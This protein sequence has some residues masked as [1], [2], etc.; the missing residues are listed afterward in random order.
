MNNHL[1]A[2]ILGKYSDALEASLQ[3]ATTGAEIVSAMTAYDDT[4]LSQRLS[5]ALSNH[6]QSRGL[7]VAKA[8]L[9]ADAIGLLS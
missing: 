6:S 9:V 4:L 7:T 3:T 2:V 8:L 5:Q 1:E